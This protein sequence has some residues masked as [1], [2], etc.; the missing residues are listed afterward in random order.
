MPSEG[1]MGSHRRPVT[2]AIWR[3]RRGRLSVS[4]ELSF[5]RSA[6]ACPV[7]THC[8]PRGA[9]PPRESTASPWY[10]ASVQS[11]VVAGGGVGSAKG[12]V[13][14]LPA[15]RPCP[16]QDAVQHPPMAALQAAC[17]CVCPQEV[18]AMHPHT[19]QAGGAGS[20]LSQGTGACESPFG[21]GG[22]LISPCVSVV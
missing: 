18:S 1:D 12:R 19:Q 20:A 5:T 21:E 10:P 4:L 22:S 2:V 9:G 14:G 15:A 3:V 7:S 8:C 13:S 17:Q 6:S 16:A 11:P